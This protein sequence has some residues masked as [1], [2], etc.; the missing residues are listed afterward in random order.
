MFAIFESGLFL[1]CPVKDITLIFFLFAALHASDHIL[2]SRHYLKL[3]YHFYQHKNL[4][5]FQPTFHNHNRLK[6]KL[7]NQLR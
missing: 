7:L 5:L 3:K 4:L 1:E 6:N 2:L